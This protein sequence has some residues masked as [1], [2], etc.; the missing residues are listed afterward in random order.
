[1]ASAVVALS[2][3]STLLVWVAFAGAGGEG[4]I[5]N[6][7]T[8]EPTGEVSDYTENHLHQESNLS[9]ENGQLVIPTQSG[10]ADTEQPPYQEGSDLEL[11][12]HLNTRDLIPAAGAGR[13]SDE[14]RLL[15]YLF[16]DY[17]PSAR[18]VINSSSTVNVKIQ[19]SLMHIQELVSDLMFRFDVHFRFC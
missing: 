2:V 14:E 12:P 9:T 3:M 1:M 8:V 16:S 18:P 13:Q 5:P 4:S 11:A 10:L 7:T 19:F 17:N 15:E 6:I